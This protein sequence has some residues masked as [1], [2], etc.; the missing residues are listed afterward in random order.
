MTQ[1]RSLLLAFTSNISVIGFGFLSALLLC[2]RF[3]LLPSL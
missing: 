2:H 1:A 3:A